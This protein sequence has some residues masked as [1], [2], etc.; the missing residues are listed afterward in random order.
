VSGHE[1]RNIDWQEARAEYDVGSGLRNNADLAALITFYRA[2]QG[3]AYGFRFK[4]WT[5]YRSTVNGELPAPNDQALGNGD[6][7]AT[8]FQLVKRYTSGA[9]SYVRPIRKPVAGTVRV[10]IN[11]IEQMSGWSVDTT[12]GVV[13]FATP[14][15]SGAAIA[16]GFEFDVPVRFRDDGLNISLETFAAGEAPSIGLVEIR[17]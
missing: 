16:A 13:T 5:D 14:P 4:D 6:G 11:G 3:R 1:Q 9:V 17:V 15:A 7:D 8:T 2:R 10:A 12:T